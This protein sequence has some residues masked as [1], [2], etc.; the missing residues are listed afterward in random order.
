[1][2]AAEQDQTEQELPKSICQP[3]HVTLFVLVLNATRCNALKTS[4]AFSEN[5]RAGRASADQLRQCWTNEAGNSR[6]IA[7]AVKRNRWLSFKLQRKTSARGLILSPLDPNPVKVRVEATAA[8]RQLT[9]I[10]HA[11]VRGA[12]GES[13]R[14]AAR[15]TATPLREVAACLP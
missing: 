9:L 10:D 5:S 4:K 8:F 12:V 11:R 7:L 6:S 14:R 15:T 13:A 2:L 3:W 1:M